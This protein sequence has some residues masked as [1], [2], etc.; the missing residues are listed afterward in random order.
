MNP[1]LIDN[2]KVPFS[3]TAVDADGNPTTLA[4]GATVSVVADDETKATIVMDA[5]PTAGIASGFIVGGKVLGTVTVTATVTGADGTVLAPLTQAIDIVAG[6]AVSEGF[7][8][9]VAVP[10]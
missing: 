1:T 5:T 7:A 3:I 8:L 6:A 4:D 10:Q 9:G 2:Y